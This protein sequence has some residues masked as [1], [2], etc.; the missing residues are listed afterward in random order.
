MTNSLDFREEPQFLEEA[1]EQS[2]VCRRHCLQAPDTEEN[3]AQPTK[4]EE[5]GECII[6]CSVGSYPKSNGFK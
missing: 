5:I 1:S 6:Y 4:E 2:I 3:M